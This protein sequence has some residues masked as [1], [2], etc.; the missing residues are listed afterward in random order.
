[1]PT[2]V[3]DIETG[4][5]PWQE[6][7]PLYVPPERLPPWDDSMV[8]YGNLKDEAKRAEK[9]TAA[10]AEYAQRLAGEAAA[11]AAHKTTWASE[12]ALSPVTGQVLAIGVKS[13]R[14][15]AILGCDGESEAEILDQW[16]ALYGRHAQAGRFVGYC[17]NFFDLPFLVWRSYKHGIA[18][19]ESVFDRTGRYFSLS[20]VDLIDRLPKRGFSD[21]S[22]KL[23]DVCHWLGLG[24]KPEG[25]D[26]S[27]F[28]SLWLS[29]STESRA[30]AVE[31]LLNDLRLTWRLGSR[32][33]VIA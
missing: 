7:E 23:S 31:Y 22:R 20:F 3:F 30:A 5:L 16:W 13:D 11:A 33:G 27:L 17:S 14:G 10:R 18:V 1:M 26:G 28:A 21:E 32:M 9:L 29:G 4:P 12:A 2:I 24:E 6:I 8:K 15:E 19:P 25:V